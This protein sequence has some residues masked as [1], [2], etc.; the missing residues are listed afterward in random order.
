MSAHKHLKRA[1]GYKLLQNSLP[2]ELDKL[3]SS[4]KLQSL[5][6][7]CKLASAERK[8][9]E[10][11]M[12]AILINNSQV[13]I[14]TVVPT[15]SIGDI[16]LSADKR[17]TK[18]NTLTDAERIRRIVLPANYWGE[19]AATTNGE[20][21]Q[22]LT[23]VLR[24]ALKRIGSE[25]LKDALTEN[26]LLNIVNLSDYSVSALLTWS[27][28]TSSSRGSITFTREQAEAWFD[29]SATK[30]E[31][32]NK[33]QQNPKLAAILSMVRNRFGSLAAKNHGLKDETDAVKLL[34][35]IA[36]ADETSPLTAEIAGR[37]AH[38]IKALAAKAAEDSISLSDIEL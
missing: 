23:D 24:E 11:I 27:N 1:S 10:T 28:E 8:E 7:T 29:A 19:L 38:I 32:A 26:P 5:G 34:A 6:Q 9:S 36:P 15:I 14:Q 22:S 21:S 25:R 35:L 2:T 33:H 13:P 20:R 31:L 12:T 16:Q 3:A 4:A 37:L 17:S 30:R 18:E